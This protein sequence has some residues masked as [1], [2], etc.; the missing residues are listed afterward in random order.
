MEEHLV[1]LI[2]SRLIIILVPITMRSPNTFKYAQVVVPIPRDEP[3]TYMIPDELRDQAGPGVQVVVPF[4]KRYL[5][6]IIL[7]LADSTNQAENEIKRIHD[8][9]G[10]EPYVPNELMQVIEWISGYYVSFLGEAYRLIHPSINLNKGH[11]QVRKLKKTP[12]RKPTALEGNLL[13]ILQNDEWTSVKELEK[14]LSRRNILHVI[15][16]LQQLKYLEKRYLPP[17]KKSVHKMAEYFLL[18]DYGNWNET[19]RQKY[20]PLDSGRL[21]KAKQLIIHLKESGKSERKDLSKAGFNAAT[22]KK[23]VDEGAIQKLVEKADTSIDLIYK[24]DTKVKEL[25]ANQKKFVDIVSP[26]LVQKSQ[27]KVFLLHGIT[28]SGKTQIYIELI[29]K[30]LPKKKQA[31]VL[32][33]EIVLT[34]QTL[35][36]F[37]NYFGDS[38]AVLHSRLSPRERAEVLQNIRNGKYQVVIGP[39]SAVFSPLRNLGLIIV[40][41]EHDSSYKQSD[42]VPRYN[43]RDVAL[44]RASINKIPVV[45]G[46][47]TPSFESLYNALN[48]KYEYF[49]LSQRILARNLPRTLVVDL[50]EEWRRTG[51]PP[52][53]SENLALKVESRLVSKEQVMLLQNRRGFA[54]YLLCRDCGFVAKCPN[55]D[56]T[57]TYHYTGKNLRCHYCGHSETA[58]DVCPQCHGLDILYKGFGTQKVEQE[59]L[60][61]FSNARILRMDQDV[62]TRKNSHEEILEKFRSGGS[63][64]L[65]GTKMIS[66]GLDFERVSLVGIISADQGLN[67]PDFRSSEK[68]FQLLTQAAGRAGRGASSGEVVIQ[69]FDPKHYIFKFLYTHD[70]LKF[71]E[72]ELESRKLLSYPPFS[73]LCL[74]RIVGDSEKEVEKY[75][76]SVAKFLW[77]AN[78]GR[79]FQILGPAPAPFFKLN[80]KYRYHILL[81]Q[82]R[83]IDP[84]MSY[85]RQLLKKR[86]YKQKEFQKWPVQIQ[87]D[88]DPMEIM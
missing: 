87:I 41:E 8:V 27:F 6:G 18:A 78:S 83:E 34:P 4:G 64:I 35:A 26:N 59:L 63:D 51:A 29:K 45:L 38:V 21:T 20:M 19:I 43:A 67:F 12:S 9:I 77:S 58:P 82:K 42:A 74:I 52:L 54:P 56:I 1:L 37:H 22:I 66:K 86:L 14:K 79:K 15:N 60:E 72:R 47:A 62:T 49:H 73:R 32:I 44:Y 68:V 31:I 50:K 80:N 5:P 81:K 28:G 61:Q 71:Y 33:P 36:R 17:E 55:C 84:S 53:L 39:R 7:D 2:L 13:R 75:S 23:L 24:E 65:I 10:S 3:F 69:T 40:D 16:K 48:G 11:L 88:M 85:L 57:L 70:Y 30:I 76:Q 46:S 25:S